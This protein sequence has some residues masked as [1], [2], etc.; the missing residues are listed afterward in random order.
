MSA[1]LEVADRAVINRP[2]GRGASRRSLIEVAG[3][4]A[5]VVGLLP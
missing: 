1:V 2:A 4:G 5:V 3:T